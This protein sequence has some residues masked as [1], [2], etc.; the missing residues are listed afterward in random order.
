MY[1]FPTD[2]F[3]SDQSIVVDY[4]LTPM[5]SLPADSSL[6]NQGIPDGTN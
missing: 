2:S 4:P 3:L 6:S 5:Y 1:S